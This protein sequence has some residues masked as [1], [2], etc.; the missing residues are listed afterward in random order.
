MSIIDIFFIEGIMIMGVCQRT[1]G[2]LGASLAADRVTSHHLH[3]HARYAPIINGI[4]N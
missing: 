2:G 4:S 3:F 1:G